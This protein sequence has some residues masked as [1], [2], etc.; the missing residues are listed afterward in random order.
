MATI[1]TTHRENQREGILDA[2]ESLFVEK[3]ID[4]VTMS[5]IAK[6]SR[7]TRATIYKYF[8]NKEEIAEEIFKTITKGWRERNE[9]E[10]WSFQGSGYQRLE[11]FI[12]SFF[13]Y[14]FENPSEASFVAELN[15][16]YAK[17]WSTDMFVGTMLE[18]LE[19]DKQFVLDSIQAGISDGS[20]RTDME[21]AL[22]LA[23]FFNFISGTISRF[24]EMGEKVEAEFG[25]SSQE[26]FT[27]IY[28]IFLD[29]LKAQA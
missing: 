18:N 28:R 25:K 8:S 1:Y 29:G 4:Q 22:M 6:K 20:L 24:G 7:L 19:E 17:H 27:K 13:D 12:T 15:Y 11:K 16:L 26:I 2:A 5:E 10:V 14:L 9:R 23:A 3:G 21:S